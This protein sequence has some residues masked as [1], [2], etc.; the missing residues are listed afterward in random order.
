[1]ERTVY[2]QNTFS[3]KVV[4]MQSSGTHRVYNNNKRTKTDLYIYRG[5]RQSEAIKKLISFGFVLCTEIEFN[6]YFNKI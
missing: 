1:M 5:K 4:I 3:N 2:L 6:N